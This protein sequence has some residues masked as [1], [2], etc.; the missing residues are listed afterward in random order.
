MI[1]DF[2]WLIHLLIII[3][4]ISIPF[5]NNRLHREFFIG[6]FPFILWHWITNDDACVLTELEMRYRNCDKNESFFYKLISPIYVI[7]NNNVGIIIKSIYILLFYIT[8]YRNGYLTNI[9]NALKEV[10]QTKVEIQKD[11]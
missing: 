5:S 8:L 3:I 10:K 1:A 6:L 7:E 2:I 9:I 4:T 11:V